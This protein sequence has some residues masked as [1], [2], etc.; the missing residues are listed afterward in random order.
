[1]LRMIENTFCWRLSTRTCQISVAILAILWLHSVIFKWVSQCVCVREDYVD[2][3]NFICLMVQLVFNFKQSDDFPFSI[4]RYDICIQK[5]KPCETL[6]NTP[7]TTHAHTHTR[8]CTHACRHTHQHLETL[9]GSSLFAWSILSAPSLTPNPS[10]WNSAPFLQ[11]CGFCGI[12]PWKV[13]K[14]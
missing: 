3:L 2:H 7:A 12:L 8:M 13:C 4:C 5:N 11:I 9:A 10:V 14:R 1:M 6:G